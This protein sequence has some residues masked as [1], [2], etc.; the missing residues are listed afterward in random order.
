MFRSLIVA[1]STIATT[2]LFALAS[3]TSATT[4]DNTPWRLP[5]TPPRCTVA[6]AES[7]DVGGC[8][9]AF[10]Y[11]PASTGWG[12]PP[13]PGVGD[14]WN[15][16]GWTYNGSPALADWEA[17]YIARNQ[18]PV[19]GL[20]KLE[21]HIAAQQLFE[22]FLS[23]IA[24]KGYRVRDASGYS[25]RCTSGNGGWSCPSGDP[26]DLSNHAWGLAV[27]MNSGTNPIRSY[28]RIDGV[29]A[30]QTPMETD[31]PRWVI[32]TAERWGLYWGGYGWNSGC[33]STSTERD[34]VYRDPPHFEFRGT[35]RQARAIADFNLRNDP[36]ANCW[37]VVD[38]A[39][40]EVE[41]CIRSTVPSA[42]WRLPI[43]TAAPTGAT[44]ALVNVVVTQPASA[45]YF[46]VEDCSPR[47]G[48]RTV[49][50]LTYGAGET[51]AGM[52]VARLSPTGRFC[53][54]QKSAAHS[55]VD[56]VAFLGPDGTPMGAPQWFTPTTG[57]RLSD[58]RVVGACAP[59]SGCVPGR[60][61]SGGRHVAA[62]DGDA[63]RFT[64]LAVIDGR[65]PGY[66]QAST[67]TGVG[68]SALFSSI[69]YAATNVRSNLSLIGEGDGSGICVYAQSEVHVIVDEV[70]RLSRSDGLGWRL[71]AGTRLIDS[72]T[73]APAYCR[74]KPGD[75]MLVRV[76]VPSSAPAVAIALTATEA[77]QAGYLW[78]G[79]CRV[80]E[81]RAE[82][83]VSHLNFV[84]GQTAS[85]L[86]LVEV[87]GGEMCVFVRGGAHV[88]VD[89]QAEL[90]PD[91]SLGVLPITP[92]RVHDSRG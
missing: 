76:P 10:Y 15:W 32:Q 38:D 1:G 3:P 5:E 88:I 22:G 16:I 24:A 46:T 82:A 49:S 14:G 73:C 27:D 90:V 50:A 66:L 41:R 17:T 61:P 11:D 4:L 33:S 54:F 8:L 80:M 55:V 92:T 28:E 53:L 18:Q 20:R 52:A 51:V 37:T 87:Q 2:V 71:G 26:R 43:D 83:P 67:C 6:Q 9:L 19:A 42:G 64:Q 63:A 70:G 48:E 62:N 78:A 57:V 91:R 21:T 60:L 75:Q 31:L 84:R 30:C 86:A 79:P 68:E 35:P 74:A 13:A 7:G 59:G 40:A 36:L 56:V 29:T 69:N 44:A 72:R 58:T 45:G 77:T 85:N 25:F 81:G 65:A 34:R 47:S 89:L 39:G 12:S 23:E